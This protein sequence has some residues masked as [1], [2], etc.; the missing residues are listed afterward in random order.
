MGYRCNKIVIVFSGVLLVFIMA[1]LFSCT[2]NGGNE[3][4]TLESITTETREIK[5]EEIV[6][7]KSLNNGSLSEVNSDGDMMKT[8]S[9]GSLENKT[10]K[11][12]AKDLEDDYNKYDAITIDIGD[13]NSIAYNFK[14]LAAFENGDLIIKSPGV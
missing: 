1:V 12:Y 8:F 5:E 2:N 14:E 3:S 9:L 11:Y 7:S 4:S 6:K 10:I 13:T